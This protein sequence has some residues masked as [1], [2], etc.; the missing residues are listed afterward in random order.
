MSVNHASWID[1]LR[2]RLDPST[3]LHTEREDE[4]W[5]SGLDGSQMTEIGSD[6]RPLFQLQWLPGG[7]QLS[8][9]YREGLYTV[10]A[11]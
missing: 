2:H 9:L 6:S 1:R 5:V 4:I 3:P 10:P 8:F 7:K 11:P